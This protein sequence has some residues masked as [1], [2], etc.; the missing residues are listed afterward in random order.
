[1]SDDVSPLPLIDIGGSPLE[2][3]LQYGRQAR[4][5]IARSIDNYR[6]GYAEA[7]VPWATAK[8]I[9]HTL[10][11]DLSDSDDTLVSEMQ[12][13]A[14]GAGVAV[15]DIFALNCRAEI[16]YGCNSSS[17]LAL[18]G[19]TGVI[20]MPEST[21]SGRLL[22]GQ[23]WDWRDECADTAIV[24][25]IESPEDPAILTQTEAGILARCGLNSAGVALTGNFLHSD[26]DPR[27]GGLP[28]PM[29]RRRI[30]EQQ[31]YTD[32]VKLALETPK[33]YSSNLMLS[34]GA[35]EAINLETVP[36]ESFWIQPS[37]GL[38]VHA[39][40]FESVGALSRVVDRGLPLLPCSLHRRRRVEQVLRTFAGH[41]DLEHLKRALDDR[42]DTPH[43]VCAAPSAGN[44]GESL[45]T[46]A[47]ILM[48]VSLGRM[49]VARRP[50][51]A[52]AYAE[53]TLAR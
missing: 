28:V 26:R 20:A 23:T 33:T 50:Y 14:D 29:L 2:R 30:L 35:G 47:T 39:N 5:L 53:Y 52:Q 7:G 10:I 27:A 51:L 46:V 15:D 49:W 16:I 3:G 18:D 34:A 22:H 42:F 44:N 9:A 37:D 31:T 6:K 11:G 19:C 17:S 25:R 45:S 13:I 1:M 40:H 36:G 32:A 4:S 12:G 48:D 38:L 24:L 41:I 21:A 8:S 43:G